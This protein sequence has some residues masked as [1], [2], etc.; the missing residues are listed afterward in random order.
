MSEHNI[1]NHYFKCLQTG[2]E[3]DFTYK[4]GS[5]WAVGALNGESCL[6]ILKYYRTTGRK[7]PWPD[8]VEKYAEQE[9]EFYDMLKDM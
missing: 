8:P 7:I 6:P 4:I 2:I 1:P 3:M 9:K 5:G